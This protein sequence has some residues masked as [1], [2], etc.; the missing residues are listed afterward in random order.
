MQ[1]F[2]SA[3]ERLRDGRLLHAVVLVVRFVSLGDGSPVADV[4]VQGEIPGGA[5][6]VWIAASP[7][8]V[9]Q[10]EV[11]VEVAELAA[12]PDGAAAPVSILVEAAAR[13]SILVEA[14]AQVEFLVEVAVP[15]AILD[16]VAQASVRAEFLAA[17]ARVASRVWVVRAVFPVEVALGV[18]PV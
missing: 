13:V 3:M 10:V 18:L 14:A 8:D 5:E 11:Q 9:A 15:V 1:P 7:V 2:P 17:A 12:I 6:Q 16:G 4:A